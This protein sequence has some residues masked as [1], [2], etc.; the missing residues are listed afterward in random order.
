MFRD[1]TRKDRPTAPTW[2][3]NLREFEI[4][5]AVLAQPDPGQRILVGRQSTD[6]FLDQLD[7]TYYDDDRTIAV[8]VTTHR[9]LP[10]HFRTTSDLR[11]PLLLDVFLA[12]ASPDGPIE[13]PGEPVTGPGHLIIDGTTVPADRITH[14]DYVL[15]SATV[16]DATIAVISTADLHD[17]AVRLDR[18]STRPTDGVL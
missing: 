9:P 8:Q 4:P 7:V 15:T 6:D 1:P 12:N 11:P 16:T 18:E 2:Q 13:I 5:V 14:G 17:R 3:E 10:A